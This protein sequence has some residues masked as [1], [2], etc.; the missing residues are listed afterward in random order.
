MGK[1]GSLGRGKERGKEEEGAEA[2]EGEG[3][4]RMGRG[5]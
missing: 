1:E 3:E 4:R 5:W 2:G